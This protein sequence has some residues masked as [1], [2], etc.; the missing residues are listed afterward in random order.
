MMNKTL[1]RRSI[2]NI[3][4]LMVVVVVC[5]IYFYELYVDEG[6][7]IIDFSKAHKNTDI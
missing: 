3:R 2:F 7:F 1:L 5:A 6:F 4:M